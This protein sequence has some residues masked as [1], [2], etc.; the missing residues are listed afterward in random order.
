MA[1]KTIFTEEHPSGNIIANSKSIHPASLVSVDQ[2]WQELC[3]YSS[4][5]HLYKQMA[6][7]IA[8]QHTS[9]P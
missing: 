2:I 7:F 6:Q 8:R 1:T 3:L 5:V 4:A 9:F